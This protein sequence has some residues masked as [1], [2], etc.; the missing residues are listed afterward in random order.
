MKP[1]TSASF[2]DYHRAVWIAWEFLK[3][4]RNGKFPANLA[5]RCGLTRLESELALS[6]LCSMEMATRRKDGRFFPSPKSL[7]I[8]E[9]FERK[10]KIMSEPLSVPQLLGLAEVYL[11]DGAP[12]TALELIREALQK[13]SPNLADS[14]DHGDVSDH[15]LVRCSL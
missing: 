9:T 3:A 14:E 13:V 12:N 15:L 11:L 1:R 5:D 4:N 10:T 7:E 8:F 2:I 6:A